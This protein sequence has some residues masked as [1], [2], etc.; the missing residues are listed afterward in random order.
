MDPATV[1]ALC[2]ENIQPLRYG[3][4][5]TQLGTALR[6]QED[7][8]AQQLL[9][10]EKQMYEDAIKNY[11]GDDPLENWYEYILWVEQSYP[12]SGHESHIGRLLQQCLAIF[13]K[14]VKYHQDR[15]YIRLWINYVS[16][17]KNPLEL[18]QLLHS[19]GI[20]TRVADMYRAWAFELE[21]IEDD[22]RADEVYLMGLSVHAEPF[23][24]LG[25]A[26]QN[27]QF[28][29][30]RK[31][32]GRIE[33]RNDVSLFE[34]R[35]AFSS[36]RAIRAGKRVGSIRTGH[37]VREYY[38]GTVPQISSSMQNTKPNSK[39]QIYQDDMPG[40]MKSSSI[41][42]HVPIEDMVHKENTIKPGPW[43]SGSKRGPLIAPTV[44]AGF[45]IHEDQ[46]DDSNMEKIKLFPNHIR[47][48]DGSKY[49]DCL[50]VP[51]YV[52]EPIDSNIVQK[53]H[54]PKEL[55][56][57]DNVDRSMEEIRAQLYLERR[58]QFLRNKHEMSMICLRETSEESQSQL[59]NYENMYHVQEEQKLNQQRREAE[60]NQQRL[61]A[62]QELQRQQYES[63]V[64]NQVLETQRQEVE[65]RLETERIEVERLE[66]QRNSRPLQS[67]NFM[68]QHHTSS[69]TV[70]TEE[71]LL[72]QSLT[73]NTKEAIS[74]VQGL[75]QSPDAAANASRFRSPPVASRMVDSRNKLPF[76][77]HMDSS[78]T[79]HAMSSNKHHQ[80][81]N[82]QVY[83]D[84]ENHQ[85]YHTQHHSYSQDQHVVYGNHSLQNSYHYQMQQHHDQV[86][87]P[88]SRQH[89]SQHQHHHQQLIP[90]HQQMHAVHHQS[91]PHPQHLQSPHNQMPHHQPHIH[92]HQSSHSHHHQSPHNHHHQSPHNHHQSSHNHHQSSHNHHQSPLNHHQSTHNHHQSPHNQH[93][94]HSQQ[95]QHVQQHM[96]HMQHPIYG[97]MLPN[98][99]DYQQY[100]MEAPMLPQQNIESQ[101]QLHFS[102]YTDPE[103]ETSKPYRMP[104][105][106]P[107][108]KSPGMNRKD[109]K[110]LESAEDKENAIVVDYNSSLEENIPKPDENNLYIDESLGITPL[111]A[112]N[113]TC[114]TEAFNAPLTSSTP[115]INHFKP[116]YRI[117]DDSQF[118]S[119]NTVSQP[120]AEAP[121]AEGDDKLSVILES[122]REYVS[123]SSGSSN[124]TKTTG[125]TF[126]LTREDVIPFKE[127]PVDTILEE[128]SNESL[129][130]VNQPYEQRQHA[131]IQAVHAQSPRT[132]QRHVDQITSEIKNNCD[133]RKSI[134]LKLN[135]ENNSEKVSTMEYEE[136]EPMEQMEE[137][138]FELP[139]KDI[140]PFDKN[141][142]AGLLKKI[143]FPQP[144]HADGYKR[145][146]TNLNKLVPSTM[147]T[148]DTEA[149]D[150][151]KCL[152]KGMYGTVYKSVNL[153]TGE[154]VALKT[155]KPAWV[156]E[157]Y[158]V[159]EIKT[160][161]TNP[162][163]LRGFMDV[164]M[165]YVA[166]N[167]S[168]L[169]SEYSKF[170][171]L[172]EVTNQIK[173]ATGKPLMETLTIFFTIEMLQIVEYL[174]KCQIIHGD[175]KPDNFLL[176][177]LPTQDVRPTI[178]LIDFGCSIDMKLFPENTTFMQVIKTEDFT[179]I[180]M[181]TGRP[182]TYQ[183]DLYCLAATSHCLLFGNYMKVSN[184]GGRWF[185][186]SKL[187]RYAKRAAWE[188]FFME[189]LNIESCEKM[190]DLAK[191]R[192]M[193]E[194][195]LAQMPE[196]QAKFRTFV[197][198]LNKR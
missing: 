92:H 43:N 136:H 160:R 26:H 64:G 138:C 89:H 157:Y 77:I 119:Q 191:L 91:L 71:H 2:K 58:A 147:I 110:Y 117:K 134:N 30:A 39:I 85:S 22:K 25:H 139:S 46:N 27:F 96:Q 116:S 174:H 166:N 153:Q 88:H 63:H 7:V 150:L 169:V 115:M 86:Q 113:E 129:L 73:V 176:M 32:L 177:R 11:E 132:V 149:Y 16:M 74:V 81:Y 172:L 170:G 5:A 146:D 104:S 114:F 175:I 41:L 171:T 168:V 98:D 163:M 142:I 194:E 84:Q 187:P 112:A 137:E 70:D 127:Q 124:Y 34:Q 40:E 102:P 193:M 44:K 101:K 51:V 192:N 42:D 78:M 20:G 122:T 8:D 162:H 140:N 130:S 3:R 60:I 62:E 61:Q 53:P 75:W 95:P 100:P 152:G 17:Q 188:Q 135:E 173:L 9:L 56:Y 68:H 155:Q 148:L 35:Q 97:N 165:A 79:Q 29:V 19:S 38:P 167:G 108:I 99:I 178:Q 106:L 180:E 131:Q 183:T 158:I 1:I 181:Q 65:Q 105:E 66:V 18:Y 48:F 21:Q 141:L 67:T 23:E 133:L 185:I 197:N 182:W 118:S 72:G 151:E 109:I 57:A 126:A 12:K 123:S 94:L 28:A 6:A 47:F 107:Y 31:T 179:C 154:T 90:L 145:I 198:I 128:E 52:A 184:M 80:G 144:H 196:A 4:N 164:T 156:W 195:T 13:E 10:Q 54:Y 69:L 36:L 120:V 14:D 87:Q 82:V 189:L 111:S 59:N 186:A 76:D 45:K 103:I 125:L 93:I 143:K 161:L 15:R 83:N 24:E 49:H 121:N 33:E 159:R 37:R 50:R 190:P 55:V